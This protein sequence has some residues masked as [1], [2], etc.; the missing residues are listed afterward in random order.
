[1]FY[2]QST[3]A[4]ISERCEGEEGRHIYTDAKE[5]MVATDHVPPNS[6]FS[7]QPSSLKQLAFVLLLFVFAF[8]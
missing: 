1:M 8:C 3:G 2:A 7:G 4:V 6:I 5:S